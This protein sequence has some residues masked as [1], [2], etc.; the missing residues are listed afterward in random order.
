MTESSTEFDFSPVFK[1]LEKYVNGE[2]LAMTS[3]VV[4]HDQEIVAEHFYGFQDRD[5][6][7]PIQ[8]DS[9]FR[10]FSNT[11]PITAI[12]AMKLW[13][14]GKFNLD[15]ELAEHIP[16]LESLV[17]LKAGA[18]DVEE[19]EPLRS[20]PTIRQLMC[21]SAGFSY[22]I[23]A[24]SLV[25]ALYM[26]AGV[27][28]PNQSLE[29]L[30]DLVASIPLAYQPGARFQ[31][32]V[33]SDI[34]AR[35]IEIWSGQKFGDYLRQEIFIPLGMSDTDFWV[36]EDKQSRFCSIYAGSDEMD[37]M[38]PG[39]SQVPD[40]FGS[41][42]EQRTLQSGGGGLVG[43]IT[44]YT[45]FIRMLMGDGEV[46]G[47]RIVR[48]ET[49]ALMRTNQLP[50]GVSVQLPNWFMPDTVFGLGLALKTKPAEGE[51]ASAIDE[52]HWGG[53]AGT[54]SWIAPRIGIAGLTFT[55]RMPGFWH[56]FSHDFKRLVYQVADQ[57]QVASV[58]E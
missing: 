8:K 9:I 17:A 26:Q 29:E 1:A 42:T 21:H 46:D 50:P 53:L 14:R 40:V 41:Y 47:V 28:G 13:E 38:K 44:D 10:L 25:D 51:P 12:A 33:A 23:F 3:S 56:P 22:G 37:P 58:V 34:L 49:L 7:E 45:K 19:T 48:P 35:L 43:T 52:F 20:R 27:L 31:Y 32:S 6:K 30:V 18:S 24:E 36:P 55:Q 39:L 54:H 57:S 11:K 2:I 5:S 15:D 16:A 4:I